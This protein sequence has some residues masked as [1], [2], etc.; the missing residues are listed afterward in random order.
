MLTLIAYRFA[1]GSEVPNIHY[2]TRM[3]K[4]LL[5]STLLVFAS[6]VEVVVT[7]S[8]VS[9]DRLERARNVDRW[10]RWLFPLTFVWL[11]LYAFAL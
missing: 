11:T 2:L 8:L 9:R 7:S 5:G 4:F 10:A 6:L 1:V 3:D